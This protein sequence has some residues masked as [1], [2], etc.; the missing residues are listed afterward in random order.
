[1]FKRNVAGTALVVAIVAVHKNIRAR[2]DFVKNA[3]VALVHEAAGACASDAFDRNAAGLNG[4]LR[5]A[6]SRGCGGNGRSAIC[7]G[8]QVLGR[9]LVTLQ[10]GESQ[11]RLRRDLQRQL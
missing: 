6:R 11:R 4:V 8:A 5:H 7:R 2:L 1:M 10:P 3:R 9:A